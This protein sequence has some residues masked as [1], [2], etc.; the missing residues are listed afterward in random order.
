MLLGR[1]LPVRD[2]KL[3]RELTVRDSTPTFFVERTLEL[4]R[5]EYARLFP[6]GLNDAAGLLVAGEKT[7]S[8][9]RG[10]G[11]AARAAALVPDARLLMVLRDPAEWIHSRW[12]Q[13][14]AA[15][16]HRGG[17]RAGP[18]GGGANATAAL[19]A[20][21]SGQLDDPGFAL[22]SLCRDLPYGI[23]EWLGHYPRE[24]RC[25]QRARQTHS[26]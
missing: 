19:A 26:A 1:A 24:V 9:W 5:L 14:R 4:A 2:S 20:Q 11:V 16:G 10:L 17:R 12:S 18:G 22:Y 7:P 8:Y 15:A 21:F 23:A 6:S 13:G 25:C 3:G